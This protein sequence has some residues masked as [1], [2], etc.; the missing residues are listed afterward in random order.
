ME[1]KMSHNIF[2][3]RF[4]GVREPAWHGLGQVLDKPVP[5]VEGIKLIDADFDIVKSPL[6]VQVKTLFGDQVLPYTGKYALVREPVDGS[7]SFEILGSCGEEY[8]IVQRRDFAQAL[9]KLTGRWPLETIGILGKGET[10]FFTLDAGPV[11]VGGEEV[12]QYFLVHDRVDGKTSA[13]I[14]FTPVR[15][16]CQNTLT[17]G[18]SQA[19]MNAVIDHRTGIGKDVNFR[20][21]LINKMAEAQRLTINTFEM[22]AH[23]RLV[24][25]QVD[26]VFEAAYPYPTKPK[27]ME[28]AGAIDVTDELLA[29]LRGQGIRAAESY[30]YYC[31]RAD[32]FRTSAKELFERM[33]AQNSQLAGSAWYAWQAVTEM[34]DWRDGAESVMESAL[35]GQRMQEKVRAFNMVSSFAK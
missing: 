22:L 6:M 1:I 12:H 35:F 23:T 9:D 11:D 3:E 30:E 32:G 5:A 29:G 27:K 20:I 7:A 25:E 28:L 31:R 2:G 19:T 33:N 10:V 17:S 14:A 34:A 18:L 21:D 24:D 15:V 4:L 16:V 13:K 8:E 26:R